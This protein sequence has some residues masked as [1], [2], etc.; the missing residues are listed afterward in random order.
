MCDLSSI[1]INYI[2]ENNYFPI[3]FSRI[4]RNIKPDSDTI[5]GTIN[6]TIT[7]LENNILK[8]MKSNKNITVKEL[9]IVTNKSIRIINGAILSLKNKK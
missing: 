7:D 1:S 6:G 5:N 4:D 3:E 8:E 2:N 9:S